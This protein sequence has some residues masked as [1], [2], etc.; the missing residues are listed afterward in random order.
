[1]SAEEIHFRATDI[2]LSKITQRCLCP[3]SKSSAFSLFEINE[4]SFNIT[5]HAC[6]SMTRGAIYSRASN[7]FE[8]KLK[9]ESISAHWRDVK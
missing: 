1:M 3:L 8:S 5:S 2:L 4:N 7:L 6:L 9:R